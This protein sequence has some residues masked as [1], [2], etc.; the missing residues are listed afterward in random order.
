[1]KVNLK[2]TLT[3]F[4]KLFGYHKI[5]GDSKGNVVWLSYDRWGLNKKCC[6]AILR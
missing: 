6:L 5:G 4:K 2:G 1:M 3:Q